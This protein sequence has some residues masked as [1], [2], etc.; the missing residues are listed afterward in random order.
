MMT[1]TK[2]CFR[3]LCCPCLL[4]GFLFVFLRNGSLAFV[5]N[6][7][8]LIRRIA[9][10]TY[11]TT[12]ARRRR[13]AA[14][15]HNVLGA[16]FFLDSPTT[17]TTAAVET[18]DGSSIVDPV[19]VSNV[20]WTSLKAKFLS[21]VIGQIL[22]AL[23]FVLLTT[24]FASQ[25][26]KLTQFVTTTL[27]S[28]ENLDKATGTVVGKA[29]ASMS[30]SSI[31]PNFGKLLACILIDVVGTSSEAIPLLGEVTD[32]VWAPIAGTL[33]RSLYGSNILF[34]LE[35]AEEILPFTDILPLATIW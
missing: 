32:V 11:A 24:F 8:S 1:K 23:V 9:P 28:K 35:F 21:V 34:V 18:F 19:V 30:N 31:E 13:H 10:K 15:R 22:A 4:L 29:R 27:F 6:N 26:Q 20:S 33:L 25:M 3:R 16:S 5:Q 17:F 14:A 12:T 7:Y 2:C